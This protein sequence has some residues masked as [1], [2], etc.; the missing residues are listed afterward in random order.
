LSVYIR[1]RETPLSRSLYDFAKVV[2]GFNV[3][4]I[5]PLHR[6]MYSLHMGIIVSWRWLVQKFYSEPLFKSRCASCGPGLEVDG[7]LPLV[8]SHLELHIGEH[9]FISGANSFVAPAILANPKLVIG[10]RTMIGGQ[11]SIN[12]ARSVTIGAGCLIARR[13]L[14]SDNYGHPLSPEKRH[15]KVSADEIKDVVIEDN[16]WIG[17]GA[18][19]SP[20][21]RIGSGAIVAANAVVTQD[22]PTNS[23]VIGAPARVVRL[24]T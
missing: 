3:P 1:K 5:R 7:G 22:V 13:V 11:T 21:V 2:K 4:V 10:D 14:I 6:A 20:G 23:V 8:S 17:N 24:L 18:V 16:V 9:V 19:I 15:G 12:V